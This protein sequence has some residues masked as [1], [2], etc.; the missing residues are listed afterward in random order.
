MSEKKNM[1]VT[2]TC[3][4][5]ESAIDVLPTLDAHHAECDICQEQVPVTFNENHMQGVL[6][7]CPCCQRRDFYKQRDF[8]R[9][10]G[11]IL[12]VIAA[13]ASIWT[14]GISLIALWL[15]DFFLFQKLPSIAICYKC[16]SIFRNVAN[17]EEIY[18]FNH[19]MNDRIVY[20]DH[21]F[22]GEQLEH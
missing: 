20:S 16:Q 19:E 11:V 5:C 18:D 6:K 4:S 13:I 10:I 1:T 9:K 8:N 2:L 22:H 21:D 3:P 15:V 17:I 7:E 12:F 14:Y